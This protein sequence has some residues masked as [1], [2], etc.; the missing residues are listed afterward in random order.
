MKLRLF[1]S[2]LTASVLLMACNRHHDDLQIDQNNETKSDFYIATEENPKASADQMRKQLS[3]FFLVEQFTVGAND[4]MI[5]ALKVNPPGGVLFWNG[6]GDDSEKLKASIQAYSVT[7]K[8]LGLKPLLFSTDY[9][10]GA[11]SKTPFHSFIPGVQRFSKGFTKLAHPRW[12]GESIKTYGMELCRLHG[13]LIAKELKVVGINYP[14]SVVSDLATQAL[15]SIRGISKDASKVSDCV[16]EINKQFIQQK[17]IIFVTKHFPGI[18][19]TRGDTHEGVVTSDVTDPAKLLLHLKPFDDLIKS[20]KTQEHEES[21]SIMTTHAKFMGY[22]PNNLATESRIVAHGLLKEKMQFNGLVISDAMWMGDYGQLQSIDLMPVYLNAFI[23]GMDLLMIPGSRFKESVA[24]FRRVFDK[25]ITD[26]ERLKLVE[27]MQL[28]FDDIHSLF[29]ARVQEAI[30]THQAV[31]GAV[32][33]PHEFIEALTPVETTIKDQ[34]RYYEIL[35]A[36]GD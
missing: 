23:S 35:K 34:E 15:T 19:L 4:S 8:K 29:I 3:Q 16:V 21:L 14:L 28:R 12:L 5:K 27:K 32:K 11:Y 36:L 6:G 30:Y 9:E 20:T 7:A 18:G 26:D 25:K 2:A 1:I 10:G 22:D 24:Y 17:D 31:R 13:K 33:H